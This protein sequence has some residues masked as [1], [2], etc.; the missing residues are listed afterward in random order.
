MID[1]SGI[2]S[3]GGY[4]KDRSTEV[5]M[6]D[7]G[8]TCSFPDL[9]E[10]RSYHSLDGLNNKPILCG[11][12]GEDANAGIL[13]SCLQFTPTSAS[14]VWTNYATTILAR[15]NHATWVSGAGLVLMGGDD[16]TEIVGT[17]L[18]NF[19]LVHQLK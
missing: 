6:L 9:P 15:G 10:G 12:Y 11:G 19:S 17:G 8:T 16:T 5:Y 14:G 7:T 4:S 18:G 1:I 2:L 13:T 3:V